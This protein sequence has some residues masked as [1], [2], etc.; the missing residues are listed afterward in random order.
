[1]DE[2]E[3]DVMIEGWDRGTSSKE[4]G[5]IVGYTREQKRA[6][7]RRLSAKEVL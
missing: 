7:G 4:D 1:M 6:S 5:G 2:V 3:G